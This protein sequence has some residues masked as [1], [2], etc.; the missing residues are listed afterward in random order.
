MSLAHAVVLITDANRGI[1][2]A[3]A[4]EA[5]ARGAR[6]PAS[7][8]LAGVQPIPQVKKSLSLLDA[9]YLEPVQ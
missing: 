1:E 5:L 4:R 9:A 6:D 7:V 8:Q 3:F 2:L